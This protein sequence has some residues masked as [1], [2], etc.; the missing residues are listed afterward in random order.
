M[1]DTAVS[2]HVCVILKI[3][4]T[5]LRFPRALPPIYFACVR[6]LAHYLRLNYSPIFIVALLV[7]SYFV[8]VCVR[9]YRIVLLAIHCNMDTF[10]ARAH[11]NLPWPADKRFTHIRCLIQYITTHMYDNV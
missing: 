11:A 7:T 3:L 9:V 6:S 1:T 2:E 4:A 8:C 10:I 5:F